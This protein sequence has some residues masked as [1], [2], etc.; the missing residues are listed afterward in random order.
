MMRELAE[1]KPCP[2]PCRE[3]L[4]REA[5]PIYPNDLVTGHVV[6]DGEEMVNM[7]PLPVRLEGKI[8]I[9]LITQYGEEF[10]AQAVRLETRE[11]GPPEYVE[12]FPGIPGSST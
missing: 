11:L 6:V 9:A 12:D 10:I 8:E 5:L 7:L 1:N 3:L 2:S 4:L